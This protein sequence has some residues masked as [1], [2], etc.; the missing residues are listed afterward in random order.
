M[1]EMVR[2]ETDG[3]VGIIT[4]DRPERLNALSEQMLEMLAEVLTGDAMDEGIRVVIITGAGDRAF[5]AGADVGTMKE[6][7]Q[8]EAQAWAQLGQRTFSLIEELPKPVIA[9]INGFALG[10][11]CEMALACDVR[12]ASEGAV[13]G[14]PEVTLGLPPGFGGTYRLPQVVGA[15]WARELIMTGRRVDAEKA[16]SMGLVTEVVAADELMDRAMSM[17]NRIASNGP[18]ALAH[19]KRAMNSMPGMKRDDAM[20]LEAHLFGRAFATGQ[21]REGISAFLEKRKA[22]Y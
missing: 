2:W 7:N 6:M 14:Q 3:P 16:L 18:E 9:A 1:S 5:V 12:L 11:G 13:L 21:P 10:G 17:A 19:A 4:L 8:E 22:E 15:G 20:E